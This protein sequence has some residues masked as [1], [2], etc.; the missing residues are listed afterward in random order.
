MRQEDQEYAYLDRS[1]RFRC[2][3]WERRLEGS[4]V[5]YLIFERDDP[6]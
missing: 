4:E 1:E 6:Y 5:F 3:E 2:L